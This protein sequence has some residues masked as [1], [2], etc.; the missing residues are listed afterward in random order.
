ME[1]Q[2]FVF[3]YNHFGHAKDLYD[4]FD[5]L[6]YETFLLN[7]QAPSDTY[8]E[9]TSHIIK[10]PNIYY[11]GQWNEMLR[12]LTGD[13]A[14]ITNADVTIPDVP[15]LMERM[16][17]FYAR[18]DAGLYAPNH[19]WTPWTY[20]PNLL[21]NLGNGLREC[22]ATDSTIWSLLSEIAFKV[23]SIDLNANYLGWGIEVVA[24]WHC[25]KQKKKVVRDYGIKCS[26]PCSSAYNREDAH[27][28]MHAWTDKLGLG[29]DFWNYYNS[30]DNYH[31]GWEGDDTIFLR[32]G[33][34]R[35]AL[36]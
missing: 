14:F 10:L 22:P 23:G 20:N 29:E 18:P 13:V 24:A 21:P 12:R 35:K 4:S 6:G 9:A 28:Q 3:N 19:Y 11:S 16:E 5:R 26:H 33:L 25:H 34:S 32:E 36:L 1:I 15:R 17:K 30:R 27:N 31:F 2:A 7:C 8:F